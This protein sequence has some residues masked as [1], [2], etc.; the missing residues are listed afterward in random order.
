MV[1][2]P[3][4]GYPTSWF[5]QWQRILPVARSHWVKVTAVPEEQ[6][7]SYCKV[8]GLATPKW[9][10]FDFA[11]LFSDAFRGRVVEIDI[12]KLTRHPIFGRKKSSSRKQ[13]EVVEEE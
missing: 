2:E 5:E 13:Y 11:E 10:G 9:S 12:N 4:P 7:H 8:P 6:R 1:T 3:W